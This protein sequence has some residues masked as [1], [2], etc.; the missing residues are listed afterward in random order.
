MLKT[1]DFTW[2]DNFVSMVLFLPHFNL[3]LLNK[4]EVKMYSLVPD[5]TMLPW[6]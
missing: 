1:G 2:R 6:P 4:I 5:V 3:I